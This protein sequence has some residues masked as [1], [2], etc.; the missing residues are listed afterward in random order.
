MPPMYFGA[1]CGVEGAQSSVRR[2]SVTIGYRVDQRRNN[3]AAGIVLIGAA[4][5]VLV[6]GF[7]PLINVT[8]PDLSIAAELLGLNLTPTGSFDAQPIELWYWTAGLIALFA[9]ILL[10]TRIPGLGILWRI[11]AFITLAIIGVY[12]VIHW[13]FISNYKQ[14]IVP[15]QDGIGDDALR[16]A[17][18]FA[19]NLGLLAVTPGVGLILLS[20]GI[21]VGIIAILLPAGKS[22]RV[23]AVPIDV[24]AL[25]P[26]NWPVPPQQY[27]QHGHYPPQPIRQQPPPYDPWRP[28]P[29]HG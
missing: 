26:G 25:P 15:D 20:S 9:V 18:T 7:L 22:Q 10:A 4:G 6:S 1:H 16:G 19:E 29:G 14:V 11:L 24:R 8:G 28:P 27:L 5:L 3:V 23:V 21:L 13:Y 12:A 2:F 17:A